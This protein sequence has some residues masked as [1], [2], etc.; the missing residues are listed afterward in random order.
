MS[1]P[2]GPTPGRQLFPKRKHSHR[3]VTTTEDGQTWERMM[4]PTPIS[5]DGDV[6]S[7][8]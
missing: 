6:H 4:V 1:G 3:S 8:G 2:Y 7:V 5:S